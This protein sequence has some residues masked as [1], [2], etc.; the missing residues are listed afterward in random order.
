MS[1]RNL[2]LALRIRTLVQ[3]SENVDDLRQGM[4][5]LADEIEQAGQEAQNA[6]Q[7]FDDL[8]Q[9][10]KKVGEG[11]DDAK[12]GMEGLH[13]AV[14]DLVGK[15]GEMI[16]VTVVAERFISANEEARKLGLQFRAMTG[17]TEK[18]ADELDYIREVANRWGVTVDALAPA[19]LRLAAATKGSRAEGDATRKMIDDLSAAYMNAGAAADDIEESMEILGERFAEG[20]VSI[21]DIKEGMQEDMPPAIQAAT[22][23][24]LENNEAL[25]KMLET[26]S[27]ATEDFMPAFAAGL[28]EHI[29]GSQDKIENMEAAFVRMGASIDQMMV[30]INDKIPIMGLLVGTL[31][32][33]AQTV[34]VVTKTISSG[35]SLV[36]DGFTFVGEAV[37]TA[38]GALAQGDDALAAVAAQGEQTQDSLAKT[39]LHLVGLKTNAERAAETQAQLEKNLKQAREEADPYQAAIDKINQRLE[40][41]QKEFENTADAVKLTETALEEFFKAPERNLDSKGVMELAATLQIVA[42]NA[43]GAGDQIASTLGVQLAKLTNEQLVKLEEQARKAMAAAGEN[44]AARKAFADLGQVIEGVVLARF[45]RLGVDGKEALTGISDAASDAIDDFT[46]LA[47]NAEI[48]ADAI[49]KAFEGAL[50]KLD[51]PEEIEKLKQ[52]IIE[53][54]NSGKLTGEQVERA[55]LLIRQRAQE[56]ANDAA[57][58]AL[59]D[60][61]AKIREEADREAEASTRATTIKQAQIEAT[62]RLAEAKGDEAAAARASADAAETEVEAARERA[63]QITREIELTK[64]HIQQLYARATADGQYSD[65]ERD[66]IETL[67][68]KVGQLDLERQKIEANL[69]LQERQAQQAAILAG[70]IGQLSRLYA[71]QTKEH[72]RA[73]DASEQYYSVQLKEIEGAIKVAQ[74]RGD[75]AEVTKLQAKQQKILIEQAEALAKAKATEA[76]DA[77]KAVDAKTLELAADGELSKADQEQIA[78]LQAVADQKKAAA[79]EAELHAEALQ[80]ESDALKQV[81][82]EAKVFD[83]AAQN[84]YKFSDAAEDVARRN[85]EVSETAEKAKNSME[86]VNVTLA[87]FGNQSAIA[88]GEE[89]VRRFEMVIRDIQSAINEADI[90]A[91]RLA[92]EGL[93]GVGNNANDAALYVEDL[94]NNLDKSESYL[95]DAARAASENLRQALADAR[96]EAEA[97][98]QSLAEAA[99][100]TEKEILRLQ[101]KNKEVYELEHQEKLRQLE[102]EY[103]KAGEL[104]DAEYRRA[105]AAEDALHAL[106]LKQLQEQADADAQKNANHTET[107]HTTVSSG[108]AGVSSPTINVNVNAGNARLLD[109][110]FKEELARDL[111]PIFDDLHRRLQ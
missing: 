100:A 28:R 19:Y 10:E 40:D 73:A 13:G 5:D 103:K 14:G 51:S 75:E 26:G 36:A 72:Q 98:V 21:A 59:A 91:E 8:E 3:G 94:A 9:S 69:P 108:S 12:Q 54:G 23:A 4:G 6:G 68:E 35:I 97:M 7:Q 33:A 58:N 32:K 92:N 22:T 107:T 82:D 81:N 105:K 11:A 43:K 95:N 41:A 27:A 78:N 37:G 30:S 1:D 84:A 47:N 24:V 49:E 70:P 16:A 101:G 42:Q 93:R 76:A 106:K 57:F 15:L 34:G 2:E 25:K 86:G 65:A 102:E 61:L 77:E 88:F 31:D 83:N 71:E 63:D 85:K 111:K 56:T 67:K 66:V 109:S 79:K 89:G 17:D 44:E 96:A 46:A 39:A 52:E 53:L 50:A 45:K 74:A 62:R 104:G 20:T 48:S 80:K 99:D 110:R 55:L 90:A 87:K 18:A 38:A 64:Q 60:Q 29:G